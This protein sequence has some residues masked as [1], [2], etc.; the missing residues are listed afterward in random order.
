MKTFQIIFSVQL[1]KLKYLDTGNNV[2]YIGDNAIWNLDD[3]ETLILGSNVSII[4]S[5][6]LTGNDN[7]KTIYVRAKTPPVNPNNTYIQLTNPPT[8]I[9]VEPGYG[10]IYKNHSSWS[11]W[12]N[13]IQEAE[14]EF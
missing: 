10:D 8:V 12:A 3:L 6:G 9:W 14:S 2:K 4:N 7:L 5:S 13:V 1:K 11:Y